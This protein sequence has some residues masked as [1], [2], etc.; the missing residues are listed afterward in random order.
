M[1]EDAR[2]L[3]QDALKG[4]NVRYI[5]IRLEATQGT[6][7]SYRGRDLE[8][9]G[10]STGIGGNVRALA[11]GG[12]GFAC[13][14]ALDDLREKVATA[15]R[16]ARLVAGDRVEIAPTEPVVDIVKPHIGKDPRNIS[17][18]QKKSQLDQYIEAIWRCPGIASSTLGYGDR[19]RKTAFCNSEG[20]YVEQEKIDVVFRASAM[21]RDGSDV[22]QS[23][24]SIGSNG[25]YE[26]VENLHSQVEAVSRKACDLL[27]APHAKGGEYSVILDPLLAG[28]FIHEAFGHLSE[29]DHVYENE[30]LKQIMVLGR[31]FGGKH[32][33]VLDGATMSGLRGSYKYDDEGVPATMT[34]LLK[35]G[36]L[37][38]RLHSR[39]TASRMGEK[40]TGNARAISHEFP[41]IVRMTNTYI[42]NGNSTFEDLAGE[43]KEGIYACNCFGGMTSMEQFTFSAGEAYMIRGGKVAEMVRPVLL[44]GNLFV[45][46]ENMD[47]I[48]NDRE[49]NEG[50]GCG[51]G[52]QS[53]LGVSTGSPHIRIRKCLVS[54]R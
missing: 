25:D 18:A 43:V 53:P 38:S 9:I 13:F 14:N 20:T 7:I 29:A 49:M 36:I 27:K 16:S 54:G 4:H 42:E 17:L 2:N 31:R 52:G 30:Q 23:H 12:W 6:R 21:A 34:P 15:V 11:G 24:I 50:G 45:T 5:E 46:L 28:V 48:A 8:E 22:Q 40:P 47:A 10:R 51:K 32:L 41:P 1:L 39:E 33:N 26:L 44:S 19:S 3:I 35:E 37:V